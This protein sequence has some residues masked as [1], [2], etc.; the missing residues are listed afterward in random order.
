MVRL[1]VA[2][3]AMP[4]KDQLKLVMNVM[5]KRRENWIEKDELKWLKKNLDNCCL[6]M[7]KIMITLK[8]VSMLGPKIKIQTHG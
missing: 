7:F 8:M 1:W 4:V 5:N 3:L 6:D 2:L